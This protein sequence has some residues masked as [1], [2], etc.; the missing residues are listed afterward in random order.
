MII[1]EVNLEVDEEINFKFAG[2][3][4][5]HMMKMLEIEGFDAAYWF[6]RKPEDEQKPPGKTLWTIHYIVEDREALEGYFEHHATAMREK[7][8]EMFGDKFTVE[9]R[10]LN[11]LSVAGLPLEKE[12]EGAGI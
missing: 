5:G 4:P 9:R 3:L 7:T 2:W 1:Y 11:L 6:F 8:I 10:I 12:T